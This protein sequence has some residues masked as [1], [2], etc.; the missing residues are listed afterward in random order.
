MQY[1][2]FALF[3]VVLAYGFWKLA[4]KLWPEADIADI[5][6]RRKNNSK[7]YEK[8]KGE[9]S[10]SSTDDADYCAEKIDKLSNSKN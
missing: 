4:C 8:Y 6:S 1:L 7:L 10:K 5:I 9:M 3:L 2:L